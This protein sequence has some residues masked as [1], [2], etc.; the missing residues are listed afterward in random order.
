MILGLINLLLLKS[1]IIQNQDKNGQWIKL[2]WLQ[3]I[4]KFWNRC[5]SKF[6]SALLW[7]YIYSWPPRLPGLVEDGFKELAK[8]DGNR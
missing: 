2:K 7:P 1:T 8:K 6:S 5:I 3:G 4:K